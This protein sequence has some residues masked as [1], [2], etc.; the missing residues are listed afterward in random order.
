MSPRPN[1]AAIRSIGLSVPW[2]GQLSMGD[3]LRWN[4]P[5]TDAVDNM[6]NMDG[7]DE[8]MVFHGVFSRNRA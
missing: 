4:W 8:S 6:D 2:T 7:M 5:V 1:A 3:R